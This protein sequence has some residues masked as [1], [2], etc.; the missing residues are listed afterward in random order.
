MAERSATA[1]RVTGSIPT[2]K[3]IIFVLPTGGC[4]GCC[5]FKCL[6]TDEKLL[7]DQLFM[8]LFYFILNKV[9]TRLIDD[10]TLQRHDIAVQAAPHSSA[11]LSK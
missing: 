10:I 1:L 8:F 9:L 6:Q 2:R 11:G 4:S 3:I 5:E 7:M